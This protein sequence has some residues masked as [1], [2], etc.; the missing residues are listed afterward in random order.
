[1]D[2][3][4]ARFDTLATIIS[5]F[6][7]VLL[8]GLAIFFI[9]K[10]PYGWIFSIM[11]IFILMISY[12]LS[13]KRYL[14]EGSKLIVEKVIGKRIIIS[15]D[16]IKGY[17]FVPNLTKLKLVRTFGNGGLFGYYGLFSSAEY[18]TINC[19]LTSLKNVFIVKSKKGTFA[20]SPYDTLTFEEY[21]KNAVSGITGKLEKL[22]PVKREAIKYAN[23]FI[24]LIPIMIFALTVVMIVSLYPQLPER[25]ATHFNFS[26]NPDAWGSKI[27]F[28]TSGIVPS[29]ILFI[30]NIV[31]FFL[32]RRTTVEPII[33]NFLVI[34]LSFIQL[35]IAYTSFDMYWYNMYRVRF[36]P[37]LYSIIGFV[38]ILAL[39]FIVY[40]QKIVRKKM[41]SNLDI[42]Q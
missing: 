6:T 20:F 18:G 35:F 9:F 36:I 13:P 22:E 8:V 14:F 17:V 24:L 29:S 16:E 32:V 1:M 23:P 34:I 38:G 7:I 2:F 3:K 33:P 11:M 21:F 27:S 37:F 25:I 42:G 31:V 4:A 10:T 5:G 19:Q 28:I 39:L 40:Y 41:G 15:L 12:L 30:I 26:G